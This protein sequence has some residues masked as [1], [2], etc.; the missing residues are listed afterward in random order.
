MDVVSALLTI[1]VSAAP[2]FELRGGIPLA[3]SRGISPGWALGLALVGNLAVIPILLWGLE[4]AEQY[5]SRWRFT[6]RFMGWVLT[7]SRRKGKWIERFGPI[8]LS[9]L[10]AI[11]LPGTGAWTGAIVA[12]LLGI[13]NRKA[14]VWIT[15]GVLI[16]G[17]LVW[18]ASLGAFALFGVTPSH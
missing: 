2:V 1:G 3:L 12:R 7:R 15:I 14:L 4:R 13:P 17:G 5:L 18:G 10:V 9:L 8:G 6:S 11:P 16:A